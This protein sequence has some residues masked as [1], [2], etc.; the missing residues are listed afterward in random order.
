MVRLNLIDRSSP[1]PAAT[2]GPVILRTCNRSEVYSG[3]GSIPYEVV[4]HLFRVI[5]GLESSLPGEK[6]IQG[7]VK[8]AYREASEKYNLSGEIHQLFQRALYVG[9]KVRTGTG[10][11][12]GAVSHCQASV[13]M[14]LEKGIELKGSVA[15]LIG[16]HNMN[17]RILRYLARH[18]S[19]TIYL[20]NRTFSKAQ[21]LAKKYNCNAF[22]LNALEEKLA[23]SEVVICAT[24]A[25]HYILTKE[26]TE[27]SGCLTVV[28]LAVPADADP[29]IRENNRIRLFTLA[30]VE[31]AVS[32]NLGNRKADFERASRIIDEEVGIFLQ[33]LER[34]QRF[35]LELAEKSPMQPEQK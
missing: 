1:P 34:K 31:N 30:D 11:D 5:S 32:R 2:A 21:Q 35:N 23:K 16:A 8:A 25:P 22:R 19:E 7:Q 12:R 20:G 15:T 6:A 10:I 28:D 29:M 27:K 17:E 9:K 33:E 3:R 26:N 13:E 24:S 4:R 18:G 14:L